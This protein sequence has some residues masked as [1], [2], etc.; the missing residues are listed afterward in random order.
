MQSKRW[1]FYV[2]LCS[3]DSYYA[4]ITSNLKRRLHEHNNTRKGAKYTRAR[5]PSRRIFHE[6][7]LNRS[8]A[9][10]MEARFKSLTRE[11]K[12]CFVSLKPGRLV[13]SS[14]HYDMLGVVLSKHTS[15]I[16]PPAWRVLCE[17][18]IEIYF[19]DELEICS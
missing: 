4:G 17:D 19:E 14:S 9:Q 1:Y 18:R 10:K 13:K 12:E 3:D 15:E 8:D 11:Q 5:R 7:F 2:L 16:Q 6:S